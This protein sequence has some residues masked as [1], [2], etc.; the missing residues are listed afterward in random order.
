M[1]IKKRNEG[2]AETIVVLLVYRK[3]KSL[4]DITNK[5]MQHMFVCVHVCIKGKRREESEYCTSTVKFSHRL[6]LVV[7]LLTIND[8]ILIVI[9]CYHLLLQKR[10]LDDELSLMKTVC[11]VCGQKKCP[12]HRYC[13][14]YI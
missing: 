8:Y 2:E 9:N 12:R 5:Q 1:Y 7:L 6:I 4:N 11:R 10:N 3:S 14:F 13:T